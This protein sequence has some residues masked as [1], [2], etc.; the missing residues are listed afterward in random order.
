MKT[1]TLIV[2]L[3]SPPQKITTQDITNAA[4]TSGGAFGNYSGSTVSGTTVTATGANGSRTFRFAA[5]EGRTVRATADVTNISGTS[6]GLRMSF[7]TAGG[8]LIGAGIIGSAFA[9]SGTSTVSGLAPA[10]TAFCE[11]SLTVFGISGNQAQF[12]NISAR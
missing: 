7:G 12:V 10:G 1:S 3:M 5:R 8:V 9:S 11:V 2:A 6:A 4:W